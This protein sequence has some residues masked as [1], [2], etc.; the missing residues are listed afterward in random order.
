MLPSAGSDTQKK[1]GIRAVPNTRQNK[2]IKEERFT[3]AASGG[4]PK[5]AAPPPK[6]ETA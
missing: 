4:N 5:A 6:S 1:P 3:Q 2:S